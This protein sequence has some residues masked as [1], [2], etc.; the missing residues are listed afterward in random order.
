M[1]FEKLVQKQL[2]YFVDKYLSL[3]ISKYIKFYSTQATWK[4]WKE[5]LDQASHTINY[6]LVLVKLNEDGISRQALLMVLNYLKKRGRKIK[7]K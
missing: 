6:E 7:E 1:I 3:Y 5:F 2:Y 4:M